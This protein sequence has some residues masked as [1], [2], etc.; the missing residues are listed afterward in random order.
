MGL[1]SWSLTVAIGTFAV[2]AAT[3]YAALAQLRHLNTTNQLS[4]L[5]FFLKLQRD[6]ELREY[7]RF[8]REDY[9]QLTT[10][11]EFIDSM[12]TPHVD[13]SIHQELNVC[14]W[15]E[16]VGALLKHKLINES[17]FLDMACPQVILGDWKTLQPTI[18][19]RRSRGGPS[20]YMN[21]EY[22]AARS[23]RLLQRSP[24]G[25]YP[26]DTPRLYVSDLP[27]PVTSDHVKATSL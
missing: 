24:S 26:S 5:L 15:Y 16:E 21:F 23:E 19:A 11:R 25:T 1:E 10:E 18:A 13:P 8:I 20:M 14:D 12:L 22:L 6:K 4:C 2:I 9:A 7:F 17:A 27:Q 3:A